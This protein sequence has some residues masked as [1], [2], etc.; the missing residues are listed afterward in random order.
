MIDEVVPFLNWFWGHLDDFGCF[1]ACIESKT[2]H[3][4]VIG[5]HIDKNHDERTM[6]HTMF[7]YHNFN[8][9]SQ[10][11]QNFTIL[12]ELHNFDRISQF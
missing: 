9:I 3:V 10:F 11:W 5:L 7:T 12:T 4:I 8:K 2:D 1:Y 6:P